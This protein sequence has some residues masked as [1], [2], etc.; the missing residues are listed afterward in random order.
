MYWSGPE[1]EGHN[2]I[3]PLPPSPPAAEHQSAR[4]QF[5]SYLKV[6][7]P[8]EKYEHILSA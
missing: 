6:G 3:L 2:W 8:R 1:D 7:L 4:N 5:Q